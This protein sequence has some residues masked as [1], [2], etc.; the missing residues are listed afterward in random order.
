M[1]RRVP[2]KQTDLQCFPHWF[3]AAWQGTEE[4]STGVIFCKKCGEIREL[5]AQHIEA[6]AEEMLQI[7]RD[8]GEPT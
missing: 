7:G 6:P 2:I 1:V 4:N 8:N 3:E 5:T